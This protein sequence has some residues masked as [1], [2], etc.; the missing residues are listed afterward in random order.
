ML[1]FRP[2]PGYVRE[3][4]RYGILPKDL[5]EGAPIDVYATDRAYWQSLW[6]QPTV[7][8]S[9]KRSRP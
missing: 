4:K 7:A 1:G 3:M 6:W 8:A 5:T 9:V 2:S